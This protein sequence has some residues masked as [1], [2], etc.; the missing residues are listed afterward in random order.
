MFEASSIADETAAGDVALR[1]V[2][3]YLGHVDADVPMVDATITRL[4]KNVSLIS[5]AGGDHRRSWKNSNRF[6]QARLRRD[7]RSS[8][9]SRVNCRPCERDHAMN[10]A[11]ISYIFEIP[12]PGCAEQPTRF[13]RFLTPWPA[14]INAGS[15]EMDHL[16][17]N[18]CRSLCGVSFHGLQRPQMAKDAPGRSDGGVRHRAIS[19]P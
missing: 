18:L 2:A 15:A 12:V 17:S 4:R 6:A 8:W 1:R 10:R 7:G 14:T 3:I 9:N 11:G 13:R 5:P 16:G 19:R